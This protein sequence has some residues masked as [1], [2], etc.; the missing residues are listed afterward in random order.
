MQGPVVKA[1]YPNPPPPIFP[2]NKEEIKQA[3]NPTSHPASGDGKK[4]LLY[5]FPQLRARSPSTSCG[6]SAD[7]AQQS[8]RTWARTGE[9]ITLVSRDSALLGLS[10]TV[11]ERVA[12]GGDHSTMV[13]FSSQGNPDYAKALDSLHRFEKEARTV[14]ERHFCSS[15]WQLLRSTGFSIF[16]G[17]K[18]HW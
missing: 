2:Y 17:A 15:E 8:D 16:N 4:P 7:S 3:K 1:Q 14:V 13:K 6:P 12:A 10:Q 9:Y 11:E 5:Q 18:N